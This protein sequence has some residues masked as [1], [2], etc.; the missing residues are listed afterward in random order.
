[1]SLEIQHLYKERCLATQT[2]QLGLLAGAEKTGGCLG[3]M[4]YHL[5]ICSH[6]TSL[7]IRNKSS[8][9]IPPAQNHQLFKFKKQEIAISKTISFSK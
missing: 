4:C 1:M 5:Q 3:W 9:R 7:E 6:R 2:E 8:I